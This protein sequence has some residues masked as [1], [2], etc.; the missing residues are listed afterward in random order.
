MVFLIHFSSHYNDFIVYHQ[1]NL[2][3]L[4]NQI[5]HNIPFVKFEIELSIFFHLTGDA[6]SERTKKFRNPMVALS[7][8]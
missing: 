8:I 7:V 2:I 4:N 6:L 5:N 1:Y 3:Y